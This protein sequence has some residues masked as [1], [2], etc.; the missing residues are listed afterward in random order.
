LVEIIHKQSKY[1]KDE[2][3]RKIE[4]RLGN[5]PF[6]D[7]LTNNGVWKMVVGP[8]EIEENTLYYGH[9]NPETNERHGF[10]MQIWPDGSKYVGY[11]KN[12]RTNGQ[13]RLIHHDGDVYVGEWKDDLAHGIGE[14]TDATGMVYKGSWINDQQEGKGNRSN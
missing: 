5:F 7:Q 1:G 4:E 8:K 2:T 9:W 3:V 6:D 12:D 10:G 11:W 13:G 14:Y